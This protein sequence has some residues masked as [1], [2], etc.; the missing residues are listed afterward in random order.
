ME[1][2]MKLSTAICLVTL[3]GM[4]V[5][6]LAGEMKMEKGGTPVDQAFAASMQTMMKNMKVNPTGNA[7]TDFVLMMMPHHQGAIDM[8]K[9]ELEYG[10]DAGDASTGDGYRCGAGKRDRGN[11]SVARQKRQVS[12]CGT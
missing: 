2:T 6:A 4:P 1:S 3:L 5:L 7:D 10:K 9:L 8:A 11:E 12:R